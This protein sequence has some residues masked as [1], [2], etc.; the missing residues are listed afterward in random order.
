[1]RRKPS[2]KTITRP[3]SGASRQSAVR[4]ATAST[5]PSAKPSDAADERQQE[6]RRE[7]LQQ[8]DNVVVAEELR[9]LVDDLLQHRGA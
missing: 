7:R 4:R 2:V 5:K 1:M 3:R 8:E 9:R 6:R